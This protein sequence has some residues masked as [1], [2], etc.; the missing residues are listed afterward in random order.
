MLPGTVARS[1]E[2]PAFL[3]LLVT[4]P[5]AGGEKP[6][7]LET[8]T[9]ENYKEGNGGVAKRS[10]VGMQAQRREKGCD[11]Y[12]KYYKSIKENGVGGG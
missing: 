5:C 3:V 7:E 8:S 11:E 1:R 9:T 12:I 2:S 10:L 4:A 6:L